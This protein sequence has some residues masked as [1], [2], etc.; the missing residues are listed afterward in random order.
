[1][2]GGVLMPIQNVDHWVSEVVA[3]ITPVRPYLT[4]DK[5][6]LQ[7]ANLHDLGTRTITYNSQE[8]TIS[9][10]RGRILQKLLLN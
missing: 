10:K 9:D 8:P 4:P 1:M 7:T 2:E 5:R 3:Y 6:A